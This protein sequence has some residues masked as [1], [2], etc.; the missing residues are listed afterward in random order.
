MKLIRHYE[1]EETVRI[2][3]FNQ[4]G[5][6]F[7]EQGKHVNRS[8]DFAKGY[9]VKQFKLIDDHCSSSADDDSSSSSG[10]GF[11]PR[12]EIVVICPSIVGHSGGP[13]VND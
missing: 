13:C 12:E 11:S 4:G 2:L 7:L 6:G 1:L 5:E 8:A 3:G 9:I 10:C